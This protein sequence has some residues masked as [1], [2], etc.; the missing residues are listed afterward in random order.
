MLPPVSDSRPW[1]GALQHIRYLR[2]ANYLRI[3][4]D[5]KQNG[6]TIGSLHCE[7]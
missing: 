7:S 2:Q 5:E 6:P 4:V 1:H 3:G